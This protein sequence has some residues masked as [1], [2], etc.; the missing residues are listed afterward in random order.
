MFILWRPTP[1]PTPSFSN[2]SGN[3]LIFNTLFHKISFKL[4][5]TNYLP[6]RNQ[7]APILIGEDLLGH[8]DGSL[9]EPPS[10]IVTPEEF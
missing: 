10:T 3:S 5:S 6:W 8:I 9:P 7:F 1:H 2:S 4:T